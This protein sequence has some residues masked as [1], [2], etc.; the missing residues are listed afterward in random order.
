MSQKAVSD[1]MNEMDGKV[2]GVVED[3]KSFE[4]AI[5]D[6][7]NNYKPIVIEGNVTNAADEE[8]ITSENNLLKL[9]D[10]SALNGM[11]Y[12]ILR[13][14]KS[15]AE[16]VTK[17]NTIYEIRY[18]F[19]LNGAEITIP[20]NCVLKFN[21]GRIQNGKIYFNNTFLIGDLKFHNCY[22]NNE[23]TVNTTIS[24]TS[25][26]GDT[27]YDSSILKFLLLN[28]AKNNGSLIINRDYNISIDDYNNAV[29]DEVNTKTFILIK[30]SNG[31]EVNFNGHTI[32][33]NSKDYTNNHNFIHLYRCNNVSI[34]KLKY[35]VTLN[36][37][38]LNPYEDDNASGA[39]LIKTNGDCGNCNF[40]VSAENVG[41]CVRC[42]EFGTIDSDNLGSPTPNYVYKG[43]YNS[44][45]KVTAYNSGY[46]CVI[47]TGENIEIKADFNKIHRGVYLTG[48][49]DA[50]VIVNGKDAKTP[51]LVLIKD[52]VYYDTNDSS[53]RTRKYKECKNINLSVTDIGSTNAYTSM[54]SIESYNDYHF[55]ERTVSY[56]FSNIN[57]K[58]YSVNNGNISRG[59]VINSRDLNNNRDKVEVFLSSLTTDKTF[60]V[61]SSVGNGDVSLNISNCYMPKC[62]IDI[63]SPHYI[64]IENSVFYTFVNKVTEES[65]V[66]LKNSELNS[67]STNN[68]ESKSSIKLINTKIINGSS[69]KINCFAGLSLVEGEN[70]NFNESKLLHD[71]YY[72]ELSIDTTIK[73]DVS[74]LLYGSYRIFYIKNIAKSPIYITF[75][76]A[77]L[78]EGESTIKVLQ[79]EIIKIV[80]I[81]QKNLN[82]AKIILTHNINNY[83]LSGKSSL[84][85]SK[86]IQS[87]TYFDTDLNQML[88]YNG[89]NWINAYGELADIKTSGTF[90]D[91][92]KPNNI[93]F[94]YFNTDTHKMITWDGTKWWNPDGT[95]ATN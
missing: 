50:N 90:I 83:F 79:N 63:K 44:K 92:P 23:I 8:D 3:E 4:D 61:L 74:K 49:N 87:S 67:I 19:D 82:K 55:T 28:T 9:K 86:A 5:R 88:Y 64:N 72:N 62:T 14:N 70:L 39:V 66:I 56:N 36:D 38:I 68:E 78:A 77:I 25:F 75:T 71:I 93:G 84:R 17:K 89:N 35:I 47:Y 80:V 59:I 24:D 46:S 18:D 1:K 53:F 57:V 73:F 42:G 91:K 41:S 52:S 69:P 48:V 22:V 33:E 65:F 94:Q 21:G 26:T 7:V 32:Y 37:N 30:F 16:Q 60:T 95:E 11:G 40:E 13:K 27:K 6:Q 2:D 45:L 81:T 58:L 31:F 20:E 76:N 15:F 12:V 54:V 51:T 43:L 85:P 34:L 10:R 29:V